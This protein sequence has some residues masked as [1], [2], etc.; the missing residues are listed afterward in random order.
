VKKPFGFSLT[1]NDHKL[2]GIS[3]NNQGFWT[4]T[5]AKVCPTQIGFRSMRPMTTI[6]V[7]D[8]ERACRMLLVPRISF[9]EANVIST[10]SSIHTHSAHVI[11]GR[12]P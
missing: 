7:V 11:K 10:R 6:L 3:N 4:G 12:H 1:A 5:L 8:D 2:K 9:T